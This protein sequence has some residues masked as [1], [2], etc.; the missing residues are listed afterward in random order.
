MR[1]SLLYI[2]ILFCVSLIAAQIKDHVFPT[3]TDSIE[4]I[5]ENFEENECSISEYTQK[6][7][8]TRPSNVQVPSLTRT[9]SAHRSNNVNSPTSFAVKSDFKSSNISG[10]HKYL[11]Y[12]ILTAGFSDSD[13]YFN[14]LC[15]LII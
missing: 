4:I 2:L 12:N 13:S 6:Q 14:S 8:A 10:A 1:K 11:S 15:R 7:C 5:Q 9:H 3:E